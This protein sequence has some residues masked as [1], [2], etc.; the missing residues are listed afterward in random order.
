MLETSVLS[1]ALSSAQAGAELHCCPLAPLHVCALTCGHRVPVLL[2]THANK[3]MHQTL[4]GGSSASARG[5]PPRKRRRWQSFAFQLF[6]NE[7]LAGVWHRG[8][9]QP[10]QL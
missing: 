8:L 4:W 10:W 2:K 6:G 9:L 3:A 5:Q 1:A 7:N